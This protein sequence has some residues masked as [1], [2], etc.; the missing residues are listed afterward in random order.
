MSFESVEAVFQQILDIYIR[1]IP[2]MIGLALFFTG[3]ATFKSHVASPGKV[4][5][6]NPGLSTDI[7]YA[8]VHGVLAPYFNRPALILVYALLAS[9]VMTPA[10]VAD[11]FARGAGP[12]NVLPFWG[13]L[14]FYIIVSDFLYYWAHRLFHGRSLWKYHAIH[15]SATEVDWTTEYRFH[16]VN[17]MLQPAPVGVLMLAL[18]ISPDV[19]AFFIPFDVIAGAFVHSNLNWTLGPLKYVVASPVFHRWHHTLP[20]EGGESNFAPTFA[21]WDW[22]F[23]TFY[24]PEGKLP[25]TFGVDDPQFPTESYLA[26]VIYPFKSKEPAAA[27]V[28]E[29]AK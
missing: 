2:M 5:W 6:R 18:G 28:A 4:W 25:A 15:H 11:F 7:T 3:V 1:Q 8:L 10:E 12:L 16:P 26:Q 24:M 27:A 13:Q 14:A 9:T 20:E 19:L 23:G 29:Q 21:L 22:L 17:V